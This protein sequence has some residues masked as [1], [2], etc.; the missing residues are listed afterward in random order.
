[1]WPMHGGRREETVQ[2]DRPLLEACHSA[3]AGQGGKIGMQSALTA[4]M[5]VFGSCPVAAVPMYFGIQPLSSR[6]CQVKKEF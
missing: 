6:E 2:P 1:M 3:R 4:H 5:T